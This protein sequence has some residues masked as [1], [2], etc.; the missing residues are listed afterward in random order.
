MGGSGSLPAPLWQAGVEQF[1]ELNGIDWEW[2]SMDGA[3]RH[4][5]HW[6]AK[7][8]DQSPSD[9]DK[10][11]VKRSLLDSGAWSADRHSD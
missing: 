7:K 9:R 10:C 8:P 1:D 2:L 11:G 4:L 6:E 5:P 3:L